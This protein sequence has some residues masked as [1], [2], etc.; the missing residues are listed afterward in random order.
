MVPAVEFPPGT[1]FTLQVTAV[2]D[3][4]VTVALSCCV[5]PSITL[6]LDDET[7]TVTDCGGGVDELL[8]PQPPNRMRKAR[9]QSSATTNRLLIVSLKTG[10][11]ILIT[12]RHVNSR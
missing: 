11:I 3:V 9:E 10:R 12:I 4:P 2:F 5:L 1:A 6:E 7:I 8:P